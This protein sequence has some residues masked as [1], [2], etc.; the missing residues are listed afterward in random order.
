MMNDIIAEV[1]D[2]YKDKALAWKLSRAEGGGYLILLSEKE[3]PD[4]IRVKIRVK[5][6]WV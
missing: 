2:S 4:A 3:I 1:I 5:D 6:Y